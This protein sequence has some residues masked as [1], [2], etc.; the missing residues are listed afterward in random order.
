MASS[1][2]CVPG[3][4]AR[5]LSDVAEKG[6]SASRSRTRETD[7]RFPRSCRLTSRRQFLEVYNHGQKTSRPSFAIFGLPN[8]AGECRLGL[9]VTRKV[10]CAV[11]RN[12]V[13]RVLRG[14]FRR[15]RRG[16]APLDLVLNARRSVVNR[17]ARLLE[18]ELVES[19]AELAARS[20]L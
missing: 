19:V 1:S 13:K 15:T 5:S 16:L 17:P 18:R 12:R 7:Q 4:V 8:D 6:A 9:T 10:G 3:E 2:A 11:V 20:G 14:V